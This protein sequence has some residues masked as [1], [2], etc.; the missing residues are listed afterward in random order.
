MAS[1]QPIPNNPRFKDLTGRDDFGRWTVL[2]FAGHGSG[3]NSL[4]MCR[5]ECETETIVRGPH[6][7][8]GKSTG[9]RQCSGVGVVTHGMSHSPE[10]TIWAAMLSRCRCETSA[11][12]ERYAGRGI[13]VCKGWDSFDVFYLDMGPRP[14]PKAT[15]DRINN[16]GHYSCGHCEECLRNGWPANCRWAT[17]TEQARNTR[18]S[19]MLTFQGIT[20]SIP[21]WAEQAG[22][23]RSALY[24]RITAGWSVE[25]ALTTQ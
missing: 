19:R 11:D 2:Y 7:T 12:Y 10:F 17:Y 25:R 13:T 24:Q 14:F 9:C 1:Q 3:G 8:R 21:D 18:R 22:L 15:I 6:L 5:C 4:W 16:N 23:T 20:Q